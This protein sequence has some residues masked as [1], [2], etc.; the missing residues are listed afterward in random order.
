VTALLELHDE[1]A[2]AGGGV[3]MLGGGRGVGKAQLLA[4]LRKDLSGR[5]RFVLFGRAEQTATHPF[6]ALREPAAQA[7]AFLE[8]RGVA[9]EFLEEHAR[10]LAV[11]LPTFQHGPAPRARDKT[12]FLEALRAFFI[13][14]GRC[15]PLTGRLSDLHYADDDTR[16]AVRFLG[17]H[18]FNPEVGGL[19]SNDDGFTGVLMVAARTD[20]DDGAVFARALASGRRGRLFEVAGFSRPQLLEYLAA[21]PA[22]D[23]LLLNVI[24]SEEREELVIAAR[25]LD[26]AML[27]NWYVIPQWYIDSH[28]IAYWDKFSRP[29]I[30]P[31]FDPGYNTALFTWWLDEEKLK[32]LPEGKNQ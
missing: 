11:L 9:E 25:A 29:A 4:E 12:G 14:L 30:G 5:G 7:L 13:D 24:E 22:I 28:R 32:K 3:I 26:R 10:A 17:Q 2:G 27:H 8:N 6:S 20:D 21:H 19:R 31:K 15:G 1:L 23:K 16:E 18:L